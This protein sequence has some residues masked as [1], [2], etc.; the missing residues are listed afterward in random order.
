MLTKSFNTVAKEEKHREIYDNS[1]TTNS[2]DAACHHTI[3]Y[4]RV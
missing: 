1:A 2:V 3:T 4:V